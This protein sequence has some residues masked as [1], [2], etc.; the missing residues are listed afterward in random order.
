MREPLTKYAKYWLY[1]HRKTSN[2][3]SEKPTKPFHSSD[4]KTSLGHF[5]K[6]PVN[7]IHHNA[8]HRFH[9]KPIYVTIKEPGKKDTHRSKITKE[10]SARREEGKKGQ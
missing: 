9:V 1:V 2:I 4:I 3:N 8:T 6:P 7:T 10:E 5:D